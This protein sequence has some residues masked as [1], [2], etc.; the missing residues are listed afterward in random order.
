[1]AMVV[2]EFHPTKIIEMRKEIKKLHE[3][4]LLLLAATAT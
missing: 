4:M 3:L 1:M 2:S